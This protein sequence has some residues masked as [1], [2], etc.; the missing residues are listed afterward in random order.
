MKPFYR[1]DPKFGH[2]CGPTE[3]G[4]Q[5]KMDKAWIDTDNQVWGE[6]PP[7]HYGTEDDDQLAIQ[8]ATLKYAI[9]RK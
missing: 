4:G 9:L 7:C 2:Y 5:Y 6:P 8:Y 1:F 3:H